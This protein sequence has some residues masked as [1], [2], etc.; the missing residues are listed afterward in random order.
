M[1]PANFVTA[2]AKLSTALPFLC[3]RRLSRA[4][5][6]EGNHIAAPERAIGLSLLA[7]GCSC[8]E[9]LLLMLAS[10][11]RQMRILTPIILPQALLMNRVQTKFLFSQHHT[12]RVCRSRS[13][14][15]QGLAASG[16]CASTV[17]PLWY[18]GDAGPGNPR[19]RPRCRRPARDRISGFPSRSPSRRDASDLLVDIA[20]VGCCGHRLDQT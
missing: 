13:S 16:A 1:T 5:H 18:S 10:A 12:I 6:A 11:D 15:A 14:Q 9:T 17:L 8:Y 2:T 4:C 19:P 7:S 3:G 20:S